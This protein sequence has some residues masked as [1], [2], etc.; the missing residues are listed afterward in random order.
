MPWRAGASAK[1]RGKNSY[2]AAKRASGRS[3]T[4]ASSG[5]ELLNV[6]LRYKQPDGDDSQLFEVPVRA[7]D[8]APSGDF[9]FAAA[10]AEF[11]ML[12]RDSKFKGKAS[13]SQTIE[14]AK[15][16]LGEDPHGDRREMVEMV[17]AAS[18]LA[19][20]DKLKRAR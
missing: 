16:A 6:K 20:G 8:A 1:E 7:G 17:R 15:G 18:R 19:G 2:H 3:T 9:R 5:G 13:W 10:V 12:L 11:G 14:L 4:A